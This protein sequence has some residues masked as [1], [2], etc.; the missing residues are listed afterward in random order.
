[1]KQKKP[2][3]YQKPYVTFRGPRSRVV[4]YVP[5]SDITWLGDQFWVLSLEYTM[6]NFAINFHETPS[7]SFIKVLIL[8]H[9]TVAPIRNF[10]RNYTV[11]MQL[12]VRLSTWK[13]EV[14]VFHVK[15]D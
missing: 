5:L 10:E 13:E 11:L 2:E 7:R 6:S 9:P 3:T 8:L 14:R 1:V 4:A 12:E 15:A